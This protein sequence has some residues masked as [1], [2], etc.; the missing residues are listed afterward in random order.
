MKKL[1]SFVFMVTALLSCTKNQ[2]EGL[3]KTSSDDYSVDERTE[4]ISSYAQML[5]AS[6]DNS[7]LRKEIKK[8]AC[9]MFDGDYDILANRIGNI[10]LAKE[11]RSVRELMAN[12]CIITRSQLSGFA[13]NHDELISEI[14]RTFPNLQVSVPV[15]CEEWDT[16][17]FVPLVAFKPYDYD[18]STHT[19]VEAFDTA[20]NVHV[21]SAIEE[22]EFPVIVVSVSERVMPDGTQVFDDE[23]IIETFGVSPLTKATLATPTGLHIKHDAAKSLGLYW[24]AIAGEG[25]YIIQRRAYNESAFTNIAALNANQNYYLNSGLT[26]GK[27]YSYRIRHVNGTDQS[28]Y[29]A[30]VTSTASE[31]VPKEPL[32]L[33][34]YQM[35]Q[36]ALQTVERWIDGRP[37]FRLVVCY[38]GESVSG[39]VNTYSTLL[40]PSRGNIKAGCNP[41]VTIFPNW[42]PEIEGSILSVLWLEEDAADDNGPTELTINLMSEQQQSGGSIAVEVSTKYVVS[43]EFTKLGESK[44]YWWHSRSTVFNN[45]LKYQFG[46]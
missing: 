18:E 34:W 30:I 36:S 11:N 35:D 44:V 29:T 38:Q 15:H 32:K 4:L 45:T 10:Q 14:Q 6:L 46:K 16:E 9:H 42:D 43:N 23:S 17:N 13:G 20:G 26:A 28:A 3:V 39:G 7:D 24:N 2:N 25:S 19:T 8:E 5:A 22:P 31:R 1:I 33:V 12:S 40:T 37:E 41:N 21:L 27:Q